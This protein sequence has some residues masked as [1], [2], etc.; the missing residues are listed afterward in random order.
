MSELAKEHPRA[1]VGD[2]GLWSS[3]VARRVAVLVV[4]GT[5]VLVAP[6]FLD[7]YT[8]NILVRAF[9]IAIVAVTVDILWGYSGYLT[10][11]QAAFFGLGA[12][13]LAITFSQLGF[14]PGQA[15]LA[16]GAAMVLAAL[17]GALVGWLSFYPG[18]SPF[19]AT[20]ISLVLPI[21]LVQLIYSGG[22]F[23]GASSGVVGYFSFPLMTETW[24]R[25]AGISMLAVAVLA[26]IAVSSDAGRLLRALR[27]NEMRC[28]YLG[29]NTAAI[30]ITLLTICAAIAA[31]AGAGYAAFGGI[32]APENAGFVFGTQLV[33][34]V[35]LGG[36]G[37]LT[38][39]IVGALSIELASA[40]L[41]GILPY[42]WEL[43]VG[44]AFVTVI[45]LMPSG[46]FGLLRAMAQ[47]WTPWLFA[48]APAVRLGDSAPK[49]RESA[50][51]AVVLEAQGVARSFGALTVLSDVNLTA[52]RGELV[53]LV[54]PNGAGK[55]TL[56]KCLADGREAS[57]GDIRIAGT[58]IKGMVP[59]RI[60]GLG[61]GR[62]FQAASVFETMSVADCLR[63]ARSG[64]DKPSVLRS[65]AALNLPAAARSVVE[66]SGLDTRFDEDA[67]NLSHGLKQALELAM[68]LALEPDLVLLDEPTAGLTRS[69][70]NVFATIL[71][72]LVEQDRLCV[73]IVEHDLDFVRQISSRIVVLHQGK[74]VLDGTVEEVVNSPLVAE[75]Y[76]GH[77][78]TDDPAPTPTNT[79]E[80]R[81]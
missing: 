10:F 59:H 30:R 23:T 77:Q 9:F 81:A 44:I 61:L 35:A 41:S 36:R 46:L 43:L 13:T 15:L 33:V 11:G 37:M 7:A 65:C 28:A 31:L 27:D 74:L 62:K 57:A 18:A 34:M 78:V 19:Y 24:F 56:M 38:G 6:W 68:V 51:D 8:V 63:I 54:G 71:T 14:G 1:A 67:R 48:P 32:A 76:S 69:E 4:F 12:Y 70:R 2:T 21:V 79:P 5:L 17:L 53:S 42:A 52:R 72:R 50:V 29:I 39:A 64:R 55:T 75:I 3:R 73:L 45:V 16:L 47:R 25:V 58:P 22:N 60:V 49:A 80:A 66:A 26:H 40:Y 20:I